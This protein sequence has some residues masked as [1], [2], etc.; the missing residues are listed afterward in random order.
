M[1]SLPD[2]LFHILSLQV[3]LAVQSSPFD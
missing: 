1:K 3:Q 2:E